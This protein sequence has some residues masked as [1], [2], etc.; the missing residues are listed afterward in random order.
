MT[1]TYALISPD[2]SLQFRDGAA[3]HMG[4]DADPH[5]GAP[6]GFTILRPSW[7]AR[8]LHGHVGDSSALARDVYP[9]NHVAGRLVAALGGPER[10]VFG[11]L[12]IC[13]SHIPQGSEEPEICGLSEAQQRLITA[14]HTAVSQHIGTP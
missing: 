14:V 13:G 10:Y 3:E 9:P 11:N 5:N 8:G 4:E 1:G 6:S 12:T 2:G 7:G